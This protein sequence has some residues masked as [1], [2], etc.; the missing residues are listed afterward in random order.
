MVFAVRAAA[1]PRDHRL[2]REST[3]TSDKRSTSQKPPPTSGCHRCWGG[4]GDGNR[5]RVLS[6]G[7]ELWVVSR[8]ARST[9]VLVTPSIEC[10]LVLVGSR[11]CASVVA[12]QWH[13]CNPALPTTAAIGHIEPT[14]IDQDAR[15]AV[16]TLH[17]PTPDLRET[18]F[19]VDAKR[20]PKRSDGSHPN[21]VNGA[22]PGSDRAGLPVDV[23]AVDADASAEP[24]G[25]PAFV[26]FVSGDREHRRF[27]LVDIGR[28]R[29]PCHAVEVEEQDQRGPRGPFVAV[30]QR[31]VP[32]EATG[33][34]RS[35]VEQ[36]GIELL[37]SKPAAGA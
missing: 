32:R 15:S 29:F 20:P 26:D 8:H 21:G 10:A 31:M 37:V 18:H 36:V 11:R 35:L 22:T 27:G 14:G 4:A 13:E 9:L 30:G 6:L 17:D 34:D 19:L 28:V 12:Q 23:A 1:R 24:V 25:E 33:Q 5:T 2:Q 7:N 3:A 16:T